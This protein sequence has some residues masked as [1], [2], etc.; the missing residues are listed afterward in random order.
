MFRFAVGEPGGAQSVVW[1]LWINP[2]NHDIY[3]AVRSL[4]SQIKA[5]LHPKEL[6]GHGPWRI[7]F[8]KSTGIVVREGDRVLESRAR[9]PELTPGWTRAFG[10]MIPAASVH[11]GRA[12]PVSEEEIFWARR[13]QPDEAVEFSVFISNPEVPPDFDRWPGRTSMGTDS[14]FCTPL[15]NGEHVWVLVHT[16][17]MP[18]ALRSLIDQRRAVMAQALESD[19]VA[20]IDWSDGDPR[21]VLIGQYPDGTQ[22]F[23]DV[24][25]PTPG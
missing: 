14:V 22:L 8:D 3:I 21:M 13:P 5:S 24:L 23:V 2:R 12:L 20:E 25:L 16:A 17:T 10:V 9:P 15:G 1:R 19:A 11:L 7:S 6:P 18:P 4:A